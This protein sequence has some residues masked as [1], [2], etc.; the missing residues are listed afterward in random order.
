M[1]KRSTFLILFALLY[2]GG[3][4]A[5]LADNAGGTLVSLLPDGVTANIETTQKKTKARNLV[6]AGEKSKG[7]KAFFAAADAA[8]GE[9][10]WI[11]DGTAAGTRLVKDINPG[12][13]SS[14]INWMARFNDK[15]VFA[16]NDGSGMELWISDGTE[17]G[18]YL[19][20]QIHEYGDGSNPNAFTQIN[21]TQFVFRAK[22]IDSEE[23]V[24]GASGPQYWLWIS[25]GTEEGTQLLYECDTRWTGQDH[26]TYHY[27]WMRVGRKVFFKADVKDGITKGEELW[28]TDG[29]TAGTRMVKDINYEPKNAET[30]DDGYTLNSA[31]DQMVNFYNE[32]LF[33]KAWTPAAG[34]EP[35]ASDGTET[36]T[37]MIADTDPTINDAGIGNGGNMTEVA[38][39]PYNGKVYGRGWNTEN[40]TIQ[41]GTT[42]LTPG[43]FTVLAVNKNPL[44]AGTGDKINGWPDPGV[45]FDGV[46]LFCGQS[47]TLAGAEGNYGGE[48]H[49]TDGTNVYLQSDFEPG[50][51][52]STAH[53]WVKE[54]TV[55]SGSAY[56]WSDADAATGHRQKLLRLD[57]K[58]VSPVLVT[59]FDPTEDKIH[60]L[61]NLGG[62][63][64]FA[65]GTNDEG[66]F[67]LYCYSYRKAGYDPEKD[68]DELD[69]EY[70]TRDEIGAGIESVPA[71]AKF[72]VFPN[73][74][75]DKFSFNVE[76]KVIGVKIFD[77]TGRL[78]KAESQ[79]AS[80]SVNVASLQKGIYQVLITGAKN[81]YKSSLIIK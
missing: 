49:Y 72:T 76:E 74:A 34:N 61:R 32:K 45:E 40:N 66:A 22:N 29:T 9:E 24:S 13:A 55:V 17:N 73:P 68:A 33:F 78:V 27:H 6:V 79:P 31:I 56:W 12:T 64:L 58:E 67:G 4:F 57:S 63:L 1:K 77:L 39:F 10:L 30:P 44:S 60:T 65:R 20:K 54:L 71:S 18:T 46:Y 36:G 19:V 41:L 37:Y 70:R 2:T 26:D 81:T 11:T 35:W 50:A 43:N 5:Q 7:Y 69:I 15:V 42:D 62:N 47:G 59:N 8:N 28:V 14:D 53:N 80:N 25:D 52:G 38:Q 75:T 48:L 16:A 3:A 23:Y 21:E 51:E